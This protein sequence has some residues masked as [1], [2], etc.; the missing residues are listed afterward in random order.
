MTR[1]EELRRAEL[2]PRESGAVELQF[3]AL[4]GFLSG[5]RYDLDVLA[6]R[7]A[8]RVRDALEASG[9]TCARCRGELWIC[10]AHADQPTE[11]EGCDAREGEPCP[12]CN[13]SDP[14]RPPR[15]FVSYINK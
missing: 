8:D 7:E 13:T 1:G 15:G 11:H 4:D 2:R 9:W 6:R 5:K 14:P 3:Y 10:A 12:D